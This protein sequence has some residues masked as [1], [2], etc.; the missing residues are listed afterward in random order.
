MMTAMHHNDDVTMGNAISLSEPAEVLF[1]VWRKHRLEKE[2]ED[3]H[4]YFDEIFFLINQC[5]RRAAEEVDASTTKT[6]CSHCSFQKAVSFT[7]K[8]KDGNS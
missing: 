5:K 2:E 4:Q 8:V 3:Q 6:K 7:T 1:A